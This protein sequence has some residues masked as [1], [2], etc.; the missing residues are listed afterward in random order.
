MFKFIFLFLVIIKSNSDKNIPIFFREFGV[1]IYVD[2]LFDTVYYNKS[3]SEK[4]KFVFFESKGKCYCERFIKNKLFEKGYF[5]NS[6]DTLKRYINSRRISRNNTPIESAIT[7]QAYF[8]P[9]R[10]GEWIRIEKNKLIK[11]KYVMGVLVD[12]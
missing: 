9:L 1:E 10:N 11:Q 6:L 5:E 3:S 4:F 8:E 12:N 2:K 7:V